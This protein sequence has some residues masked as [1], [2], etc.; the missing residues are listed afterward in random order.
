MYTDLTIT[1]ASDNL[2]RLGDPSTDQSLRLYT[3]SVVQLLS[4][5][6][7]DR[8]S[9]FMALLRAGRIKTSSDI[10]GYFTASASAV[11]QFMRS[12]NYDAYPLSISLLSYTSID[13]T[14]LSLKIAIAGASGTI[15]E[16]ILVAA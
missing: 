16:N 13:A 6:V 14:T 15:I 8:G 4:D 12:R 2:Y 3:R 9:S 7:N 10:I 11:I 5:K 1:A